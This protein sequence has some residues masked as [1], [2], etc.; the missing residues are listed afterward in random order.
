[1]KK[2]SLSCAAVFICVL[3]SGCA[4]NGAV[5]NNTPGNTIPAKAGSTYIYNNTP[6][7]TSGK[8]LT[9]S[10]Y[11]SV[12]SVAATG[13]SFSGKT[14][15]TQFTSRNLKTGIVTPS[16]INFE[17]N[18]DISEFIGGSFLSV[19][20]ITL[21]NWVTYPI[22]THVSS[23]FKILDTSFSYPLPVLGNVPIHII[24]VDSITYV[25]W[26]LFTLNN[27]YIP[28]FNLKH[29]TNY[30]G[31]VRII[32]EQ[33]LFNSDGITTLAFAPSIG[34]YTNKTTQPFKV[35]LGL[36]PSIQ[37]TQKILVAYNL[38]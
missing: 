28:E 37:G 21:P 36:F 30:S 19:L 17:A 25:N 32:I 6:I 26:D 31:A 29:R 34:Y 12:D 1:M 8:L 22:Q 4:Y 35:P 38:K 10:A 7:D 24:V 9:D 13:M 5:V 3:Y 27:A 18:G 15:V 16:Y 2:L 33:P 23:G 11:Q 20:G 14:N